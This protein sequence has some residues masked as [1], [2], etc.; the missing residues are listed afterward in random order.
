MPSDFTAKPPYSVVQPGAYSAV[1]ASQ[2][3]APAAG[4]G[5]PIPAIIGTALGGTPLKAGYYSS[6]GQLLQAL[7]GGAAYDTARFMFDGGAPRVCV[8]RIGNS[9]TQAVLALAGSGGT[10]VTLTANDYGSWA[11]AIRITV[12]AG[13]IITLVYT[14]ALGNTFTEKWDLTAVS[15][16]TVAQLAQAIN[17]QLY[18]YNA[19]NF[20]TAAA[21]AGTLPLTTLSNTALAGGTDGLSPVAGDWT[22]GLTVLETEPID[23]IVPATGDATVHA[24]VQTHC[25]NLSLPNARRERVAVFGGVLGESVSN[26]VTRI[27]GLHSARSELVYPGIW[28][29]NAQG[30]LT[31][32][33][34]FYLAAKIAGMWAANPDVATSLIHELVPIQDV[35]VNLS[36]VQG[37]AI[38]QLLQAGVTPVAKADGG[39]FWVVDALTGY[40]QPDGVFRDMTKTRSADFVAQYAR[41]AL[42]TQFVGS[43]GLASSGSSITAAA[44]KI[45]DDLLTLQV[46]AAYQVP[47]V[48]R[49]PVAGSWNVGLPVMLI[50]T[51]KFIFITEQLLPSS[52]LAGSTNITTAA[53]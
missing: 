48:T 1:N 31:L 34:P 30:Q 17:G 41:K 27:A 3:S 13:P 14:D 7:R 22:N 5:Q 33:D 40:N 15:S 29:Y 37:G 8:V 39:G 21:G 20:V 24:Q 52:T 6:P 2:V 32:Y 23:L 53:S 36:T 49:G 11:N 25:Q 10:V 47:T 9:V 26:V 12:A 18:G 28:D 16:L 43:K 35:E 19:S 4:S 50:D 38:D 46:I 44:R 45:L 42:Q 51:T